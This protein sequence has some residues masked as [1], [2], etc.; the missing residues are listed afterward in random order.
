[1]SSSRLDHLHEVLIN[2]FARKVIK[3]LDDE[4]P[5]CKQYSHANISLNVL[6]CAQA[7]IAH[8]FFIMTETDQ[9]IFITNLS[10]QIRKNIIQLNKKEGCE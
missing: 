1:M 8:K 10:N 4:L 2:E 9:E 3:F 6:T 5:V 7:S